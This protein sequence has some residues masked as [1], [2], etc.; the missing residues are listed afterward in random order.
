MATVEAQTQLPIV[1]DA[2]QRDIADDDNLENTT[3][4]KKNKKRN[5]NNWVLVAKK[6]KTE[7]SKCVFVIQNASSTDYLGTNLEIKWEL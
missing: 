5:A 7:R 4:N 6:K 1:P 2:F 3:S